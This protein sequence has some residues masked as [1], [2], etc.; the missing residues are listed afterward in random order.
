MMKK[1][2][3]GTTLLMGVVASA[4]QAGEPLKFGISGFYQGAMA[5]TSDGKYDDKGEAGY[6]RH[7][8]NFKQNVEVHFG[9]EVKLDN[10]ITVGG[11][12]E[13]EGQTHSDQIDATYFYFKTGLGEVRFGNFGSAAA[14]LCGGLNTAS[15][16][17][18]VAGAMNFSNLGNN[19]QQLV[20]STGTDL[21]NSIND[22]GT[23]IAYFSPSIAGF[24][25]AISYMPDDS[26]DQP[27]NAV[28]GTPKSNVGQDS[29]EWSMAVEYSANIGSFGIGAYAGWERALETENSP[30]KKPTYFQF[31]GSV[32]FGNFGIN[33]GF[34]RGTNLD[35][36]D[37]DSKTFG[38]S[39][40]Y[41]MD[42][43]TFGF[44]WL[45]GW[46]DLPGNFKEETHDVYMITMGYAL[47]TG[48]NLDAVIQ[49]D[50]YNA[51]NPTTS[52]YKSTVFGVG[53]S[54]AF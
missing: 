38:L 27:G 2:L 25:A 50:V 37:M 54:V 33:A 46:Y 39:G 9:G 12:V 44:A 48:V 6:G 30:N 31:G 41:K 8:I 47:G 17:F 21:C 28:G 3:L 11:R 26:E 1:I 14:L 35:V 29:K 16:A 45:R 18:P 5:I 49:R 19:G 32:T 36:N 7:N 34:Q 53:F 10:G 24:R 20:D 22:K 52:D 4:A 13:L 23:K 51:K 42:A 40:T 15:T 43:F